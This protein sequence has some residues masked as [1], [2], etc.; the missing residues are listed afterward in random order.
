MLEMTER[1]FAGVPVDEESLAL[2]VIAHVGAGGHFLGEEHTRKHFRSEFY[3][4]QLADTESFDAWVKKG[5]RDSFE[6]ATGRWKKLLA[7][8]QEPK[9]DVSIDD[10]LKDFM[11]RRKREIEATLD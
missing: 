7:S 2:D 8:Y 5:S 4:P 3:F 11:A 6:R 9:L 1:F 10:H